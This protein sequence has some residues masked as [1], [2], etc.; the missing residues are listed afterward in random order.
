MAEQLPAH[1]P[2]GASSAERWMNCPGSV[3]L[4]RS[5]PKRDQVADPEYR[6]EGTAAHAAIAYCLGGSGCDAWE[7]IGHTFGDAKTEVTVDMADAIQVFLDAANKLSEGAQQTYVEAHLNDPDNPLCYGT[8]DFGAVHPGLLSILDYKHGQGIVV[9]TCNNQQMMYYAYLIL[10][11]HSDIRKVAMQIIQPRIPHEQEDPWVV[12]AE[13]IMQWAEDT[14]LPAMGRTEFDDTLTPGQ[15]CRFCEAKESLACPA[16]K[17][18]F[19][20]AAVVKVDQMKAMS[21]EELLRLYPL[22]DP[23]RMYIKAIGDETM[24]RLMD[25]R[26]VDNGVVK[27]VNKKANRIWKSEAPEIFKSRFGEKVW[28]AP[29]FKSPAEMEK[30]DAAAKKMV[31]EYAYTPQSGYTVTLA[32]DKRPAVTIQKVTQAFAQTLEN[33]NGTD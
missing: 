15:H 26:L 1:S 23:V 24:R 27:L 31:H 6:A 30:I 32:D 4:I 14:L 3:N 19:E 7:V 17:T 25:H 18:A 12:D 9:E 8:I 22:M 33:N 10:L 20:N 16:L 11:K 5:L 13:F 29:E 21:D 28:N 2:L